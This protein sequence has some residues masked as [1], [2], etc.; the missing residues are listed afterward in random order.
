MRFV[1]VSLTLALGVTACAKE[2]FSGTATLSWTPVK[3][4]TSGEA[5]KNIAGYKIH[6]GTSSKA[7][8]TVVV[9]KSPNQ[10]TYVVKDLH[11]GTWYFAVGAY[12]TSGAEGALS[13]VASKTIK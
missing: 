10:T 8:D 7:M 2:S 4:D 3:A 6:Y 12:T 13:K 1:I 5:L 11:P 9:L